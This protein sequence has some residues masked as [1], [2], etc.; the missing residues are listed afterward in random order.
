LSLNRK[1][2]KARKL[3]VIAIMLDLFT[4]TIGIGFIFIAI[5]HDANSLTE[6]TS[7]NGLCPGTATSCPSL[8]P[9]PCLTQVQ[10][11]TGTCTIASGAASC[12]TTVTFSPAYGSTPN[13]DLSTAT[14]SNNILIPDDIA[15]LL[16]STVSPI[17]WIVPAA[18]T[19]LLGD[20][21]RRI[22]IATQGFT[23]YREVVDVVNA[24]PSGTKLNFQYASAGAF[25]P[26]CSGSPVWTNMTEIDVS[27]TGYKDSANQVFPTVAKNNVCFRVVGYSGDG[28]TTS[29]YGRVEL[30]LISLAT[31]SFTCIETAI[32]AS[33]FTL[34]IQ[35]GVATQLASNPVCSWKAGVL[36]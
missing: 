18:I 6:C 34:T 33:Q 9:S 36:K 26:G 35:A 2:S 16:P 32:T 15:F 11:G 30:R 20:T 31:Q 1:E 7:G 21:S 22:V 27:T 23:N 14:T 29:G 12:S 25:G 19:E 17:T 8:V 24:A 13:V 4:F 5:G 10:S 28:L 3:A